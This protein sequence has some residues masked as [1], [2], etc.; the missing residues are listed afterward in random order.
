MTPTEL[1]IWVSLRV[2]IVISVITDVILSREIRAGKPAEA[3]ARLAN[4]AT[5][6]R[7]QTPAPRPTPYRAPGS[8]AKG[9]DAAPASARFWLLLAATLYLVFVIYGSLVPLRFHSL[10]WEQAVER[11][12]NMPYLALGAGSRADWVANILLFVPLCFLW[13][14][15]VW[16]RRSL[17]RVPV[18]ALVFAAGV[19]LSLAIE[20][21]QVYFPQ[22]TVSLNDIIAESIGAAIGIALWWALGD[23]ALRWLQ[24][25][26]LARGTTN[27]AQRLLAVYLVALFGYNLLP[28][29]LTISPVEVYHKWREGK[30]IWLPF[31]TSYADGAQRLYDLVT[32]AAIWVPAAALWQLAYRKAR[33]QTWSLAVM[34]ATVLELLQLFVYSRVSDT[35]D[36]FTAAIGAALGVAL[37]RASPEPQGAS[38]SAGLRPHRNRQ[39][40]AWPWSIAA[41]GWMAVLAFVFWYPFDFNLDR[42]FLRDRVAGLHRVPFEAYYFGTEFRAVT[43][44]LRKALFLAPLGFLLYGL[45]RRLPATWPRALVHAVMLLLIT[46]AVT[47][48][49]AGQ[50]L[51]PGKNADFTDGALEFIGA[52]LGYFGSLYVAERLR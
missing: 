37:V 46:A 11:F 6:G 25:L 10:P 18:A 38:A 41:L 26:P 51:L 30:V 12:R 23:R 21:V 20:F 36:I 43:E 15:V 49:E 39:G 48:I 14:G 50:L 22:R 13:T 42:N 29:D 3:T 9:R 27:I 33:L 44:V 8:A 47:T 4:N 19:G 31:T 34:A 40:R 7:V 45:G 24:S 17:W 52:A 2:V 16:P 1:P 5:I 28:L 32:D 35:T